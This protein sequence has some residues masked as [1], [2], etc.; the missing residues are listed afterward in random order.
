MASA[1]KPLLALPYVYRIVL[2]VI[3]SVPVGVLW[4]LGAGP[5]AAYGRVT[6]GPAVRVYGPDLASHLARVDDRTVS[7]HMARDHHSH[8]IGAG[9]SDVQ[10]DAVGPFRQAR[11]DAEL[12]LPLSKPAALGIGIQL[13][14]PP[15][16]GST[17]VSVQLR[18]NG[19]PLPSVAAS[20]GWQRYWW[21][22]PAA[23]GREGVNSAVISVS[24]PG[25]RIVVSDLLIENR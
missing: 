12:L 16:E 11:G 19:S 10:A 6:S 18:F 22:V 24:P 3:Y 21:D 7:L 5:D 15:G 4:G 1:A 25:S 17:P 2:D 9:W 20:P 23:L 8:L 14:L 13:A